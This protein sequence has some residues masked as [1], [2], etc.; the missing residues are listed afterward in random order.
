MNNCINIINQSINFKKRGF[1]IKN[2]KINLM[3][4]KTFLK[5]N[6]LKFIKIEKLQI[7][8]YINYN[9]NK[10]VFK[11]IV[12]MYKPSKKQFISLKKLKKLKLKHNWILIMSTNRGLINSYEAIK[13]NSGGLILA[14]IWN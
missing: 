12:N 5:I 6:V 7:I 8:A 14:K 1:I 9:N 10:P 4:L 13:S 2:S 11:N 3:L